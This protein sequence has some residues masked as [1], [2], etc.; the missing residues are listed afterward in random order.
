MEAFNHE[1]NKSADH[2]TNGITS[3]DNFLP[4]ICASGNSTVGSSILNEDA[5]TDNSIEFSH[6]PDIGFMKNIDQGLD[7]RHFSE[8]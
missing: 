5:F 3:G 2:Y 7:S 6:Q 4:L 8:L 1:R